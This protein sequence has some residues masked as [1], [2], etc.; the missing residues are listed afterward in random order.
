MAFVVQKYRCAQSPELNII[1][2]GSDPVKYLVH[3]SQIVGNLTGKVTPSASLHAM[4]AFFRSVNGVRMQN[5]GDIETAYR[6]GD[7]GAMVYTHYYH[8]GH[9]PSYFMTLD[10]VK[11]TL[12]SLPNQMEDIGR[13]FRELFVDAPQLQVE[14]LFK[15]NNDNPASAFEP[16]HNSAAVS[17]AKCARLLPPDRGVYVLKFSDTLPDRALYYVGKSNDIEERLRQHA[18][19]EGA[20]CV[21][22]RHFT[23]VPVIVAGTVN[24]MEGWERS[25]VLERMFQFGINAVRGW[26]FTLTAMPL[27]QKL[28]AFDDVCERFD[29]CRECGRGSHFIRDCQAL[30][31]DWWTNGLDRR[32]AYRLGQANLEQEARLA[33]EQEARLEAERR[34]AEAIRVLMG[35]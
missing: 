24:D 1:G 16:Y 14:P 15:K 10:G 26:K 30:T 18:R 20:V 25:E 32:S 22:G 11:E 3:A 27:E 31:T 17:P 13:K 29:L 19:D 35:K 7:M 34:N 12:C 4:H 8:S 33:L 23:R 21:R 5:G 9:N 28:S 2:V 6:A